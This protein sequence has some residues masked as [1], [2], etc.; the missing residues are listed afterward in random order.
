[1]EEFPLFQSPLDVAWLTDDEIHRERR[2]DRQ[3]DLEGLIELVPGR[4]DDEDVHVAI[5]VRRPVSMGAEENDL[6]GVEAC[7]DLARETADDTH[8][9]VRSPIPTVRLYLRRSATLGNHADIIPWNDIS[10][11]NR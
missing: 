1:M 4:H 2:R 11:C 8:G 3:A 10:L 7:G 6:V 9:N 5:G